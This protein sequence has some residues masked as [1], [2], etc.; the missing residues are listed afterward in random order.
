MEIEVNR[1]VWD[2]V[3]RKHIVKHSVTVKEVGEICF[4]KVKAKLAKFGRYLVMGKTKAG[5]KLTIILAPKGESSFYIVSA[6]DT[7]R[8]E[9]RWFENEKNKS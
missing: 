4:G 2:E 5:R 6:R 7:S 3:N 8:K 9:R 1:L